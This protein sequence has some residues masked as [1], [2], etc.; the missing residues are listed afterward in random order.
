MRATR[1]FLPAVLLTVL[2][3]EVFAQDP[4]GE[5]AMAAIRA[6]CGDGW[7]EKIA[8]LSDVRVGKQLQIMG[9]K[10]WPVRTKATYHITTISTDIGWLPKMN[11][12]DVIDIE[13]NIY[14]DGFGG[15]KTSEYA[16][17][18]RR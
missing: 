11:A 15:Y 3:T 2:N 9:K 7:C 1:Y 12:G 17:Y 6:Y 4:S 10:Y 13:W 8:E 18:K 14:E 16:G 5:D